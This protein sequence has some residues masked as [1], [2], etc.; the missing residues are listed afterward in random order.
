MCML[1]SDTRKNCNMPSRATQNT[2]RGAAYNAIEAIA[3]DHHVTMEDTLVALF[4]GSGARGKAMCDR[5]HRRVC[6]TMARRWQA[7]TTKD[8]LRSIHTSLE[9]LELILEMGATRT[10]Y[11]SLVKFCPVARNK[12]KLQSHTT[13]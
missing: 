2:L 6:T 9:L 13:T 5:V 10:G 3:R 12:K 4:T 7:R 11:R 8:Q 1:F